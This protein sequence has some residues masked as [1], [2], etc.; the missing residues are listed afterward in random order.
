[1]WK[2]YAWNSATCICVNGKHLLS[3]KDH[4]VIICDEVIESYDEEIRTNATTFSEKK[5]T[6]KMQNFA[7]IFVDYYSIIDSC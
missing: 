4:S 6:W 3:V 2:N 1:M 7:C 5:A